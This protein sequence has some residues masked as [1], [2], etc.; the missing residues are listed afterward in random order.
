M[1]ENWLESPTCQNCRA[2][3]EMKSSCESEEGSSWDH[4]AI[5]LKHITWPNNTFTY[6]ISICYLILNTN[7]VRCSQQLR[8]FFNCISLPSSLSIRSWTRNNILKRAINTCAVCVNVQFLR[9]N[10]SHN[11]IVYRSCSYSIQFYFG[12]PSHSTTE[13]SLC[14]CRHRLR[15]RVSLNQN[16]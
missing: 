2:K 8:S 14:R 12:F 16:Q 10:L 13:S 6:F 1:L 5:W 4:V 7:T 9:H 11:W 3:Y 15:L